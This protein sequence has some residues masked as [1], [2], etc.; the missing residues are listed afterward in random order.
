MISK[1]QID[2]MEQYAKIR[3]TIDQLTI[4]EKEIKQLI[5]PT[6]E[7][8]VTSSFGIFTPVKKV[9]YKYSK[10]ITELEKQTKEEIKEY[11]QSK[12]DPIEKLKKIEE[13]D[14]TAKAT[15][16]ISMSYKGTK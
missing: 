11:Q 16:T 6:L 13:L 12:L 14:G 9:T 15:E 5:I 7:K 8:T 3:K 10:K 4:K 1:Q 2:L